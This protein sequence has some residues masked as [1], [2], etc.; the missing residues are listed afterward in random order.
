M[1]L[2]RQ[3]FDYAPDVGGIIS[4]DSGLSVQTAYLAF[5]D[6]DRLDQFVR[7]VDGLAL[8]TGE[9]LS[10]SPVQVIVPKKKEVRRNKARQVRHG[11]EKVGKV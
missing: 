1:R 3:F 6:E 10:V 11:T 2:A 7:D 9:V 5:P 4:A 8:R